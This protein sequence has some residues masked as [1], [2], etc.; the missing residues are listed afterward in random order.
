MSA[1]GEFKVGDLVAGLVAR[2]IAAH[3]EHTG[4]GCF[5]V[6]AGA[7]RVDGDGY[8]RWAACAGPFVARGD[9][10]WGD[11][12][13]GCVGP[14]SGEIDDAVSFADAGCRD[15]GDVID[16]VALQVAAGEILPGA[17]AVD[18][19][20]FDSTL[21]GFDRRASGGVTA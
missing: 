6:Y 21:R 14:D 5:T 13:E 3:V 7:E 10:L 9:V 11:F 19:A 20:G 8:T 12:V 16:L 15:L 17:D 4:G 18:A 1:R 2:G